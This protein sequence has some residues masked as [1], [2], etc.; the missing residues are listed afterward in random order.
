MKNLNVKQTSKHHAGN[1]YRVAL[2][3]KM[4]AQINQ[5]FYSNTVSVRFYNALKS[6][7][8]IICK[9][10]SGAIAATTRK[11]EKTI[12]VTNFT[13]QDYSDFQVTGKATISQPLKFKGSNG[14]LQTIIFIQDSEFFSVN[15]LENGM[16][17]GGFIKT[18]TKKQATNFLAKFKANKVFTAKD[19]KDFDLQ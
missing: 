9:T 11:I 7:K 4:V 14:N 8:E 15:I 18:A 6:N 13:S 10:L 5:Y 12:Q 1:S 16:L 17:V 2:N 19:F 3:N